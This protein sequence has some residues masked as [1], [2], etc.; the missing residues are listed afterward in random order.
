M[1]TDYPDEPSLS[2]LKKDR[3]DFFGILLKPGISSCNFISFLL[4]Q[5]I[6]FT[7]LNFILSFITFILTDPKYYGLDPNEVGS[8]LGQIASYA[9]MTVIFFE[10]ILGY[11]F[12]SIGRKIPLVF[13]MLLIA[14]CTGLVPLG[15]NLYP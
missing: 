6:T 8:N 4:I 13:G 12:D 7:T 10:M 14:L 1:P 9:E 11:A 3:S 2:D 5:F 15:K